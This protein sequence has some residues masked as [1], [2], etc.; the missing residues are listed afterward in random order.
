M[1]AQSQLLEQE[2]PKE[3]LQRALGFTLEALQINAAGRITA[4]QRGRLLNTAGC[5]FGLSIVAAFGWVVNLESIQHPQTNADLGSAI[6]VLLVLALLFAWGMSK[7]I[8]L[9]VDVIQ[10]TVRSYEGYIELAISDR[11]KV[12]HYQV[13]AGD[14]VFRV[15]KSVFLAFKNDEPYTIYYLPRSKRILSAE[16]MRNLEA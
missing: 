15:S 6:L 11:G 10:G 14:T 8:P 13:Q 3:R 12:T 16:W 9:S 1:A 5:W 7:G 4:S 2:K